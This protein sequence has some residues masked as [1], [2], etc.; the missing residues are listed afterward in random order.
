VNSTEVDHENPL[1]ERWHGAFLAFSHVQK[2]TD[3]IV[4]KRSD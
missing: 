4:L 2:P 1:D 3:Q